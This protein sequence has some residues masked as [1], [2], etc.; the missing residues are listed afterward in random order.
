MVRDLAVFVQY[1]QKGDF[2]TQL[3]RTQRWLA[4]AEAAQDFFHA[5]DVAG[6]SRHRLDRAGRHGA[7]PRG[8]WRGRVGD[9]GTAGVL[10]VAVALYYDI[11]DRYEGN[12]ANLEM[13]GEGA[14]RAVA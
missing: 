13:S 14:L 7:R 3:D 12:E 4:E 5:G 10:E 6:R 9:I 11:I 8:F 2:R 1:A